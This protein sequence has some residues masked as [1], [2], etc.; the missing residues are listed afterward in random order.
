MN[1]VTVFL[2]SQ[3]ENRLTVYVKQ[4]SGYEEKNKVCLLQK[5]LYDLKQSPHQWYQ[6]L[7]DYLI[8]NR[9]K[10]LNSDHSVFI[11]EHLIVTVYVD[12]LLIRGKNMNIINFFKESL[13][14]MFNI[15][16]LEPVCHYLSMKVTYNKINRTLNLKQT[17]YTKKLLIKFEMKDCWKVSTPMEKSISSLMKE[18]K[19][20]NHTLIEWYTSAISSLIWLMMTSRPDIIFAV[21]FFSQFTMNPTSEH[22]SEIKYTFYYLAGTTDHDIIFDLNQLEHN[23]LYSSVKYVD[24]DWGDCNMTFWSTTDYVIFFNEEA[25]S[26]TFK[27]Q[28]TVALLSI[29]AENNALSLVIKEAV[30]LCQLL[31]ELDKY[32]HSIILNTD[33]EESLTLLDNSEF[34]AHTKHINI[35]IHWVREVISSDNVSVYWIKD[36]DNVADIFM[37][38]LD[39]TLFNKNVNR[40]SLIDK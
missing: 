3:I 1:I 17:F 19:A 35:K 10:C 27:Q 32:E 8:N 18:I 36:E 31:L 38:P 11:G 25:I 23:D 24:S 20:P 9:M 15:S 29:E 2:N 21:V 14:Y 13:T 26:H 12:N 7:H 30:W 37:K 6:T 5:M 39:Q 34:Y 16:D 40:L 28:P 33:S 4:S 22:V